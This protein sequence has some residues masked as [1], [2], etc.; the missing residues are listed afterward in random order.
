MIS[1][2]KATHALHAQMYVDRSEQRFP[3]ILA[4]D[5]LKQSCYFP[6]VITSCVC[7]VSSSMKGWLFIITFNYSFE[8]A[9]EAEKVDCVIHEERAT[10]CMKVWQNK[11]DFFFS[12]NG[13]FL[14]IFCPV[15]H[16]VS[17][18]ICVAFAG[19]SGPD[20]LND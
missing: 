5:P 19:S 3:T 10:I 16:E 2:K 9:V 13:F 7:V 1:G 18:Q 20:L 11:L 15:N 4:C 6:P 14:I 12:R 17:P 8:Y